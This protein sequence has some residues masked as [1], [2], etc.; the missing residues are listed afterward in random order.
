MNCFWLLIMWPKCSPFCQVLI[1]KIMHTYC[2]NL[3]R[4][5]KI[6][7]INQNYLQYSIITSNIQKIL[8][9]ENGSVTTCLLL[10][11]HD[12]IFTMYNSP[13]SPEREVKL[14]PFYGWG[15]WGPRSHTDTA[16][17]AW[18]AVPTPSTSQTA[19]QLFRPMQAL[20][21]LG[22]LFL[23]PPRPAPPH[24][25]TM[26]SWTPGSPSSPADRDQG[27]SQAS[28]CPDTTAASFQ[29]LTESVM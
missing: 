2:R 21:F 7:E 5:R 4:H 15:K 13:D 8:P 28:E 10:F 23:T 19:A 17:A 29:R 24:P 25:T 20:P 22:R 12:S 3:G 27:C 14:S 1:I 6:S 11:P 9:F 18:T 26:D 16:L